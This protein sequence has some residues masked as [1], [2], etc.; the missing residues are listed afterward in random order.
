[1]YNVTIRFRPETKTNEKQ[2][3]DVE[4]PYFDIDADSV[5]IHTDQTPKKVAAFHWSDI[6]EVLTEEVE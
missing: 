2:Y 6:L 1:M 3:Y 5:V 4:L